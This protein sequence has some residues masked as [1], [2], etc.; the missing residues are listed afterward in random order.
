MKQP[1]MQCMLLFLGIFLITACTR[2]ASVKTVEPNAAAFIN[3]A[4][5]SK[6]TGLLSFRQTDNGVRISGTITGLTP[7]VHGIHIHEY[8]TCN[9]DASAAGGHFNPNKSQHGSPTSKSRHAGD[10]G[11]ITAN[12]K[13]VASVNIIG[14]HISLGGN[15][16]VIGRA[17]VIHERADD[18]ITQPSGNSGKPIGCGTIGIAKQREQSNAKAK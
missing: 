10:L 11:N 13:G 8:G 5:K 3:P 9:A 18:Y 14:K 7:G 12:Q 1:I 17:I 16:N 15:N 4:N 2:Q 6:V